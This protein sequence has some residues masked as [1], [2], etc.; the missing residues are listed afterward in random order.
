MLL[1]RVAKDSNLARFADCPAVFI[2]AQNASC[3]ALHPSGLVSS[4]LPTR[5]LRKFP[6]NP[7]LLVI[8]GVEP[9]SGLKSTYLK[10]YAASHA[11]IALSTA[12][13]R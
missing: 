11:S 13:P 1:K 4:A 12:N 7:A 5:Q 10:P 8:G 2:S 9:T 3:A 6:M